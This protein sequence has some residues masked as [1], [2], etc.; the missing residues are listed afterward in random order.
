MRQYLGDINACSTQENSLSQLK[1]GGYE[2]GLTQV[3][4]K[5]GRIVM[6]ISRSAHNSKWQQVNFDMWPADINMKVDLGTGYNN[7]EVVWK[8]IWEY[9]R[10][11]K[12]A[13]PKGGVTYSVGS[14]Y[15]GG[16]MPKV[17]LGYWI[18]RHLDIIADTQNHELLKHTL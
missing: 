16:K 8:E 14:I 15:F 2:I 1:P 3:N 13:L 5:P 12:I 11:N 6:W 17:N 9:A 10:A 18:R 4:G 7:T